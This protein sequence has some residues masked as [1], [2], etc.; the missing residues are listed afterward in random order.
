MLNVLDQLPPQFLDTPPTEMYRV[1]GGPSLIHL[2]GRRQPALFVSALLHGNELT[3][4]EAVQALLRKYTGRE[5]PRALSIFVGNVEAA[6]HGLRRLERQPDYNRVW[7]GSDTDG[8]PEHAMARQVVDVMARRGVFASVDVHNNTGLNPHYACV[9]RIDYRFLHLATLFSRVVVYF[10]T[11][12]G[13]QSQAFARL[14]PAVTVECGKSGDRRSVEHAL[15]YLDACLHL[16]DIPCHP[17]HPR[18]LALFHTVATVKVPKEFSFSF[19]ER[20]TDLL[21]EPDLDHFN[22]RELA[23]GT[24]LGRLRPGSRARLRA[25]D[26]EG[27][28]VADAYFSYEDHEL[29]LARAVM[30]SMLTL[31]ARVIR[32]DCLCY[33]MERCEVEEER[34]IAGRQT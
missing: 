3:S 17:P 26:D 9:N 27:R 19:G 29:R 4:L 1:L 34:E 25:F 7:P 28:D 8:T 11:P 5:L 14:C 2:P 16:A 23:A 33:L 18:D 10:T 24:R 22:F 15:E 30:P 32:Q 20:D 31:D 21:F 6:R 13:V 12:R